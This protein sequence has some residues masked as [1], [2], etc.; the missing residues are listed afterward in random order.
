MLLLVLTY[1]C[2]SVSHRLT[3]PLLTLIS[4]Y[5]SQL[6][7]FGTVAV[8]AVSERFQCVPC[9]FQRVPNFVVSFLPQ[10]RKKLDM[11]EKIDLQ[12]KLE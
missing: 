1:L 10:T 6:L 12:F 11:G 9:L 7:L 5:S 2:P 3:F 4:C 8:I